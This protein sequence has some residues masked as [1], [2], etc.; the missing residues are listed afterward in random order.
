[1]ST[2]LGGRGLDNTT[3][4]GTLRYT[5]EEQGD[6][7]KI[8]SILAKK[9]DDVVTIQPV[10]DMTRA[11]QLMQLHEIAAL[12]VTEGDRVVGLLGEREVVHAAVDGKGSITRTKVRDHMRK[13]PVTCTPD[14]STTAVMEK[15]T[16][17]R[18]R[19]MPIIEN[20][21]LCGI[22]SIGDMV[23]FRLDEMALEARVLRDAYL[24]RP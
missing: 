8:S 4:F 21:R 3:G 11:A 24:T 6:L 2:A 22:V 20:G 9:G 13:H 10:D 16:E 23:K 17:M 18:Q 19:H 15:M 5:R 12:V 1:M 7:M 14:D